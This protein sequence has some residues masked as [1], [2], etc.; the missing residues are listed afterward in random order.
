ML[1]AGCILSGLALLVSIA[2]CVIFAKTEYYWK[3]L[4]VIALALITIFFTQY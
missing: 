4:G 3:C 2:G 1:I